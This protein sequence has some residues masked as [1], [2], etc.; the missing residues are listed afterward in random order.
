MVTARYPKA[1]WLGNGRSGGTYTGGP[2]RVV[3]HTTETA[4]VPS[5]DDGRYAPHMTYFPKDRRFYQHTSFLT[6]A[7]ALKNESGGVETNR[8][9]A[10]QLE[11]VC[12]SNRT[13][14]DTADHRLWV[15]DLTADHLGDI[16][17]FLEWTY[18]E[19]GVKAEWPG[20]QA[21]SSGEANADGFRMGLSEW[22]EFGGV[23][24]HQ[25]LPENVHWDTGALN[26]QAL[27]ETEDDEVTEQDKIDIANKV[28][29]RVTASGITGWLALDRIYRNVNELTVAHRANA[30]G[31]NAEIDDD[32][33]EALV[34]SIREF[35]PEDTVRAIGE[36]LVGAQ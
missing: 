22:N 26:W 33:I 20:K 11:I 3:L 32:D 18:D 5:Y 7:R 1:T 28:A 12:Y 34:A 15:G 17:R 25:H 6:A 23:C 2:Y 36:R 35:I 29:E 16:R 13:L 21:L 24:A 8:R 27:M 9:R 30:L 19:F 14:A 10:I 4:W 31:A